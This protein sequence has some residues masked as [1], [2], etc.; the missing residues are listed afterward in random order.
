MNNTLTIKQGNQI[1]IISDLDGENEVRVMTKD[2]DNRKTIIWLNAE[3]IISLKE[4]VDY[5]SSKITNEKLHQ[6]CLSMTYRNIND[7]ALS[8]LPK[9]MNDT[10]CSNIRGLYCS[11]NVSECY[12]RKIK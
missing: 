3:N 12:G 2:L 5:L 9:C 6:K 7:S 8:K 10:C 11:V 1:I 4:H